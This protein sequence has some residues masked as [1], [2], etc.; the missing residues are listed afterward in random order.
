MSKLLVKSLH[1]EMNM[2]KLL[3]KAFHAGMNMWKLLVKA[4]HA[5]DK[6]VEAS[7]ESS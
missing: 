6:H 2:S 7:G 3:V 4:L 1:A 5:R